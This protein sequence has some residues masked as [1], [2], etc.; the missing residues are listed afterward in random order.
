MNAY[1]HKLLTRAE[2][3]WHALG[4][5]LEGKDVVEHDGYT[6]SSLNFNKITPPQ[7]ELLVSQMGKAF[8]RANVYWK[9]NEQGKIVVRVE[10]PPMST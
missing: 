7:A 6:S 3:I 8:R 1:A 10:I 4:L 2:G 5:S 9:E